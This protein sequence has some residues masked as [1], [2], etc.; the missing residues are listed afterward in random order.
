MNEPCR[1]CHGSGESPRI[2]L[3][4]TTDAREV[5]REWYTCG[6]CGDCGPM[7]REEL[8]YAEP[9]PPKPQVEQMRLGV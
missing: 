9:L 8:L 7:L 2:V 5:H 3:L 4:H 6:V 1:A